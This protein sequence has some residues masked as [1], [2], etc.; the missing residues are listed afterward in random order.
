VSLGDYAVV[1]EFVRL[2]AQM[3]AGESLTVDDHAIVG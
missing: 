2:D 3:S 1:G